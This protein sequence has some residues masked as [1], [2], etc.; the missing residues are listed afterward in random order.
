MTEFRNKDAHH[1]EF[2][3][4]VTY[5]D[6][7]EVKELLETLLHN[8]RRVYMDGFEGMTDTTERD[9]ITKD[10]DRAWETLN[11]IFRNHSEFSQAFLADMTEG[12]DF[13]ILQRLQQWAEL[14]HRQ[15]PGGPALQHTV[16]LNDLSGCS[17][18]LDELT[19][20]PPTGEPAIWPFINIIRHVLRI[21]NDAV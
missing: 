7:S 10:S 8:F 20:D 15:R 5:M 11:S 12:A 2:M 4:E 1:P 16:V 9:Q 14:S 19:I 18:Y 21:S 6:S 13:R 3:I 17:E